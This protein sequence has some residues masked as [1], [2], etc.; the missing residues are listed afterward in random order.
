[1][2]ARPKLLCERGD[3]GNRNGGCLAG[4]HCPAGTQL[5]EPL[6]TRVEYDRSHRVGADGCAD[7]IIDRAAGES[8][9]RNTLEHGSRASAQHS[10]ADPRMARPIFLAP[11]ELVEIA[12][13]AP[14]DLIHRLCIGKTREGWIPD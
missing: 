2:T 1:H 3:P 9:K 6:A 8:R 11:H 4:S 14:D 12:E 7:L 13:N 10:V 5:P